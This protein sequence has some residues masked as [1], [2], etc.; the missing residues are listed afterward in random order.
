M[1]TECSQI[2][3]IIKAKEKIKLFKY[4]EMRLIKESALDK[5]V[6]IKLLLLLEF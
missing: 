1:H 5:S 4:I 6:K 2:R 3:R